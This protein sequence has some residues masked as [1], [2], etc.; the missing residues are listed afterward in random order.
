MFFLCLHKQQ[1]VM[2]VCVAQRNRRNISFP[3]WR[4]LRMMMTMMTMMRMRRSLHP[5]MTHS[6]PVHLTRTHQL[7]GIPAAVGTLC[8]ASMTLSPQAPVP[9]RVKSAPRGEFGPADGL[10][11]QAPE[12]ERCFPG[13]AGKHRQGPSPPAVRA[14]LPAAA[15]PPVWSCPPQSTAFPRGL[16]CPHPADTSHPH[17]KEDYLPLDPFLLFVPFHPAATGHHKLEPLPCHSGYSTGP[18]DT[19]HGRVPVQG[20]LMSSW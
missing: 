18:L 19:C 3:M 2:N 11:H 20:L 4:S 8:R 12:A 6:P 9:A 17:L 10:P 16:N 7:E 5:M 14:A 13:G 1:E 15:S